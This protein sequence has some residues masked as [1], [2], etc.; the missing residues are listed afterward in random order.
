MEKQAATVAGTGQAFVAAAAAHHATSALA[1]SRVEAGRPRSEGTIR[2]V[3]DVESKHIFVVIYVF[4]SDQLMPKTIKKART[5]P[6]LRPKE[7]KQAK[8]N[9]QKARNQAARNQPKQLYTGGRAQRAETPK[10][11]EVQKSPEN[12]KPIPLN[13]LA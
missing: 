12:F 10:R 3:E 5:Q 4:F 1:Y 6:L 13:L 11:V 2:T 8:I 9:L 7:Q